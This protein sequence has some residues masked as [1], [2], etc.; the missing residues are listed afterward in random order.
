M[1]IKFKSIGDEDSLYGEKFKQSVIKGK[2]TYK[3]GDID[4]FV[5]IKRK[6]IWK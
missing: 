5:K 1:K 2:E 3:K 4:Q 6:E